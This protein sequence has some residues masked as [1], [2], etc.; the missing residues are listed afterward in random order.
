MDQIEEIKNKIDV[1]SLISEFVPLKK[2]GRNFKG[3]CPFHTEKTPSFIVS[4]ERQ[5]WHCFGCN[6]GGNIFDFL[7]K[8]ENIEFGEALRFLAKRAGIV[9]PSYR[10]PGETQL[11]EKLYEINHLAGEFYHYLLLK[12]PLGKAGLAY[13]K[14]RDVK[15]QTISEFKLGYAPNLWQSVSKYLIEKKSYHLN[16]LETAGLCLRGR[17]YYD[18]FRSRLIFPL[19]DH[20]GNTVGFSGR[21]LDPDAKEAKYVNSPETPIYSKSHHLY[22][23]NLAKD[24][25]K[26]ENQAI[27]VEG[28][29]D[30][31]SSYQAGVKNI[32]AIKGSALTEGHVQLLKR[33]TDNLL[34]ALD[35]DFAGNNA[36]IKG[37]EIADH[38]GFNMRV[39]ELLYGKDPDDCIRKNPELWKKSLKSALPLY[40]Y[41]LK[42]AQKLNDPQTPEGKKNIGLFFLPFLSRVNNEIIKSHY[43]KKLA[44]LL[45][46][47]EE[48][49]LH[50]LDKTSREKIKEKFLTPDA[51]PAKPPA[52]G[53]EEKVEEILISLLLQASDLKVFLEETQRILEPDDFQNPLLKKLY[54]Q[55]LTFEK[56]WD[57]KE[58]FSGLQPELLPT[59]DKLFLWETESPNSS[60]DK[61]TVD[62]KK[63]ALIIKS[64]N[65]KKQIKDLLLEIKKS[66]S[67]NDEPALQELNQK[68]QLVT[69]KLKNLEK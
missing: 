33:F 38:L 40:D 43:I 69:E 39:C 6:F 63:T 15:D 17:D 49:I 45:T 5:I 19:I 16:D 41:L 12:H 8:I 68:L 4:P 22:G 30:M 13:L 65:F 26:K 14:Q 51:I 24:F 48:G 36:A 18:R 60:G 29:F 52:L 46:V 42:F 44:V 64:H 54:L 10:P 27:L 61:K 20:R 31:I 50:E 66:E 56:E 28:E 67:E 9:L 35:T 47:S 62:L 34:F 11:K 23:L 21:L 55:I 53:K 58:F 59:A 2:T 57:P 32:V 37:I 7:M 1:V 25:I 3:L